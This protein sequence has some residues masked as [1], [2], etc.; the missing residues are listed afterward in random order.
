MR[1]FEITEEQIKTL[2]SSTRGR[3][4]YMHDWFPAAFEPEEYV[5]KYRKPGFVSS[6]IVDASNAEEAIKKFPYFGDDCE[7]QEV[8]PRY[9]LDKIWRRKP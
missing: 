2:A 8:F 6:V 3:D 7:I 1:K 5:I 4:V 9:E